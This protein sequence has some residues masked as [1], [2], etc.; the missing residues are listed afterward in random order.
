[1]SEE[2][3]LFKRLGRDSRIFAIIVGGKPNV[4]ESGGPESNQECFTPALMYRIGPDGN[5]SDERQELL[6]ADARSFGDGRRKATLK[7][8]ASLLGI[9]Y[10]DLVHR[11][12]RARRV[13][14]LQNAAVYTSM[15]ILAAFGGLALIIAKRNE[16]KRYAEMARIK[17]N[18]GDYAGALDTA[19]MGLPPPKGAAI[20]LSSDEAVS[21]ASIAAYQNR[22]LFGFRS[23]SVI[24]ISADLICGTFAQA[25]SLLNILSNP[26]AAA[27]W[28]RLHHIHGASQPPTTGIASGLL[29]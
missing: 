4:S 26:P 27:R 17:Y 3:L 23:S 15:V 13:R 6:A 11:D 29:M 2:V 10:D 1:V 14:R 28:P 18:V 7:L 24:A 21:V 12:R 19:A 16:S 25:K 20:D 8:I 5:V 9:E 22:R